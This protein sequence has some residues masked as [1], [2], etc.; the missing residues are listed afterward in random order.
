MSL[1]RPQPSP[2]IKLRAAEMGERMLAGVQ[3]S[4]VTAESRRVA[5]LMRIL[6]ERLASSRL[7]VAALEKVGDLLEEA[8][9]AAVGAEDRQ[10]PQAGQ[11]DISNDAY[12]EWSPQF[13]RS[14]PISAAM[15]MQISPE[16][17]TVLAAG[18]YGRAY[19]GPPGCVHGGALA[20][21]LDE[22]CGTAAS[23]SGEVAMTANLAVSYKAPTPLYAEIHIQGWLVSVEGRKIRVAAEI[24]A[25]DTLTVEAEGL[26][27]ALDRER[28]ASLVP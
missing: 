12:T 23:L 20:G 19:E 8:V 28:F 7:D 1:T 14:N 2:E 16:T 24:W 10:R 21:T 5:N 6:T 13:G 11:G 4:E 3:V 25:G 9:P 22:V 15:T 17:A 26:F 18:T 27:I